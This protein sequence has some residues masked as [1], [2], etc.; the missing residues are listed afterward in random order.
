[1]VANVMRRGK[2]RGIRPDGPGGRHAPLHA[3]AR[4]HDDQSRGQPLTLP[5]SRKVRALIAY[6]ALAPGAVTRSKLCELLWDVPNDPRGELRWCLSKARSI[7]DEPGRRRVLTHDDAIELD[8]ADCFVD[9][10]EIA[11]TTQTG[12]QTVAP[13][14]CGRSACCSPAT[15]ST[16]WRSTAARSSMAG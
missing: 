1:V 6:L 15:S 5:S 3:H 12:I 9:A 7:L 14:R 8:L 4:P 10:I 16:A 13:E 2:V 11:R